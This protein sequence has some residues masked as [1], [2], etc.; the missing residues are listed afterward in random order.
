MIGTYNEGGV[1]GSIAH[2]F[3]VPRVSS[4]QL[5]RDLFISYK[6]SRHMIRLRN[7]DKSVLRSTFIPKTETWQEMRRETRNMSSYR[8]DNIF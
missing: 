3:K 5:C 6:N 2:V 7:S 8:R 1:T 4:W